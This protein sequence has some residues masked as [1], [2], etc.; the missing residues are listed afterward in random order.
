MQA[1]L[2]NDVGNFWC[3]GTHPV[4][5]EFSMG[6]LSVALPANADLRTYVMDEN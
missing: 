1:I 4:C 2:H 5:A 3:A 6:D